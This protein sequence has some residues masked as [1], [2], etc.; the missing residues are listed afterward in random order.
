MYPKFSSPGAGRKAPN[1][2]V[3]GFHSSCL[4]NGFKLVT[5]D[6]VTSLKSLYTPVKSECEGLLWYKSRTLNCQNWELAFSTEI[7]KL[8]KDL[9][10]GKYIKLSSSTPVD[11]LLF[12]QLTCNKWV[13]MYSW[14][15][16]ISFFLRQH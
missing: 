9:N 13:R 5:K 4:R 3:V 1:S 16:A 6:E 15:V 8:V 7:W 11:D 10:Q 2:K 14:H 12:P